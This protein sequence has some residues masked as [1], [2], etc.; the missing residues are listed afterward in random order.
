LLC[1]TELTTREDIEKL[2][3]AIKEV[4]EAGLP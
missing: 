3:S 1:A 4:K 2:V